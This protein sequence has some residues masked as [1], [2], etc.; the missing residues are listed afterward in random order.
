MN[1]DAESRLGLR[2]SMRRVNRPGSFGGL[3]LPLFDVVACL[4]SWH[5]LG[6]RMPARYP[7]AVRRHVVELARA[8]T[9]VAQLA[10]TFGMT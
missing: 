10:E 9:R 4:E 2:S 3:D 7:S 1:S 5:R 8:G 6:G